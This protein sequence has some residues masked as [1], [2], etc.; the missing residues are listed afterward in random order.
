ME[1]L[2]ITNKRGCQWQWGRI[3][4]EFHDERNFDFAAGAYSTIDKLLEIAMSKGSKG[5]VPVEHPNWKILL[6]TEVRSVTWDKKTASGVTVKGADGKTF[7]IGLKTGGS[8]VLAAG[9]VASPT[10]LMRS[11]LGDFLKDN[12]GL[13]LTD[14]DI[15]AKAY[16][17]RYLNPADRARVGAMKLQTYVHPASGPIVLA[18]MAI[19]ASSFLPRDPVRAGPVNEGFPM[20]TAAFIRPTVL[21]PDNTIVL[22]N[23][24]PVVTINR[25]VAFDNNDP[26]ILELRELVLQAKDVLEDALGIQIL[27]DGHDSD[28]GF[29]KTLELGGVAHELGTIPIKGSS[30]SYCLD[31]DLKLRGREGLY[32]CDLSVFPYSPEVNTSL[33]LAALALRL[34]RT[35]LLPPLPAVGLANDKVYVVNQTGEK[36]RVFVSNC[37]GVASSVKNTEETLNPGQLATRDRKNGVSEAVFVYRLKYNST[38]DFLDDPILLI[39]NPG[40]ILAI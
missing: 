36:I 3:A 13:H 30:G 33:T 2:N 39:A 26:G 40:S 4:S 6:D 23:D 12:G 5:G 16:T 22:K 19:D 7:T 25:Q 35:V 10:I 15:F 34:S 37:A 14:H 20:L 28:P 24:E 29:F 1:R 38:T 11:G 32:V 27:D 21:N 18:N 8:V 9:S 31:T 17:F